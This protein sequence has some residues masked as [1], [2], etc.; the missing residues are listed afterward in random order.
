MRWHRWNGIALTIM[1]RRRFLGLSSLSAL[2]V[3]SAMA[4]QATKQD[5]L[6][7]TPS[8][9][10]GP[11]YPV[12]A[13]QDKDFDLTRISGHSQSALGLPVYIEGHVVDTAGQAIEEAKVDLWQANAAGK[14]WHPRDPNPALIDEHF[15]GWAIVTSDQQGQFRFK[16]ILPGAYPVGN[17]WV[18]PPHIHFKVT[19]SGFETLTT[20]MY[21]PDQPLNDNDRL[22]QR[23]S[24][25]EQK[26]MIAQKLDHNDN[27]LY[28]KIVLQEL[29]V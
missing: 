21:F 7:S 3:S 14:Y 2:C 16:T 4:N 1:N 26:A 9:I 22:L 17:G 29:A 8:E 10:E 15:Q 18:R 11:F 19:K 12:N 28:Y 25:S 6:Q 13:Q 24:L 23:K 20:Q 5:P 27:T